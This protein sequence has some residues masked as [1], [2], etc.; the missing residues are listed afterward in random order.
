MAAII[1]VLTNQEAKEVIVLTVAALH[2]P[3][4]VEVAQDQ[5]HIGEILQEVHLEVHP[6]VDLL[7]EVR[8]N[9]VPDLATSHEMI[10]QEPVLLEV[11]P[12]QVAQ[13]EIS[14]IIRIM[15]RNKLLIVS[16]D[17]VSMADL[18]ILKQSTFIN[19]IIG[20]GSLVEDV[21][22][23]F[24]SNTYPI[25]TSVITGC[26]PNK[27]GI[28]DNVKPLPM[29]STP[30]WFWYSNDINVQTLYNQ[31]TLNNLTT[32]SILW[33]VTA[34][35]K[36]KY[37]I[38]EIFPTKAYETQAFLSL[39][40]GSPLF[41]LKSILKYR[42][43]FKG[44]SQPGLDDF[45]CSVMC[46]VILEKNPDLMLIHF[47]DVDTNKHNYGI[48]SAEAKE[49]LLRM[50]KRVSKLFDALSAV[51]NVDDFHVIIFSDHG[52]SDVQ[53]TVDPNIFLK[54]ANLIDYDQSGKIKTWEAWMK[55][56]GGSAFC[57]LNPKSS[58]S[59]SSLESEVKDLLVKE[60]QNSS[61]GFKRYLDEDEITL[62][63]FKR[64][65][66]FGISASAGYELLNNSEKAH[67]ANH[68]YPISDGGYNTF[69]FV[70]GPMINKGLSLNGGNLLEIAPLA[71]KLLDIPLWKMDGRIR[72]E[73]LKK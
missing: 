33:P 46:D 18:E 20:D 60:F 8:I 13:I 44:I 49:A 54:N 73:L 40:N 48:S 11:N 57:Y 19:K 66:V 28:F 65:C 42:N 61:S 26:Y 36:I 52:M 27:H 29:E 1:E 24:V 30:G 16:L 69:Y 6:R 12:Q 25:H 3:V 58:Q 59:K 4:Q 15:G 72:S 62:S 53:H 21:S 43:I 35:A 34:G 17:A 47:T 50:D 32:A 22:P 5:A 51:N 70:Y 7:L 37:N 14:G 67:K 9:Q 10:L 71:C 63:G 68:G 64:D 55:G 31:A 2:L 23:V 38:P 45:S 56:C 39:S 41:T